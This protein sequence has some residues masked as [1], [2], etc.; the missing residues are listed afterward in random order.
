MGA[1]IEALLARGMQSLYIYSGGYKLYNYTNQ[2]FDDF[3]NVRHHAGVEVEY[4]RDADHTYMLHGGSRA[5]HR[6]R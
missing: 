6:S 3:P 4:F 2:F 1:E 5:A